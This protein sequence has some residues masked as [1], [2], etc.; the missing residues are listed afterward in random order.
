MKHLVSLRSYR[1]SLCAA[2]STIRLVHHKIPKKSPPPPAPPKPPRPPQRFQTFSHH[3]ATWDDPY[4]W[5]SNLSDKVAMRHMDVY[6]E[7]EEKY[8][9]AV[10][11]D[12]E[13]LQSKLM[14]EMASRLSYDLATPP[15]RWGP[16]YALP[17]TSPID[18]SPL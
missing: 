12:S 13:K 18:L 5:M 1:H 10:M 3:D 9:E 11:S 2:T 7:Q 15:L 14:S 17:S 8:T 16:W 4:S 6:M